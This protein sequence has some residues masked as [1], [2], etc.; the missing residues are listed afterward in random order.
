MFFTT[1]KSLAITAAFLLTGGT[2]SAAVVIT[3]W[4]LDNVSVSTTTGA[5]TSTIYDRSATAPGALTSGKITFDGT[6]A[7]SPGVKIVNDDPFAGD[8]SNGYNCI[9][10]NSGTTCNGAKQSGKRFKFQSTGSA[11]T[12]MVFNVNPNGTFTTTG[13]DGVYKV[14]QAFGN[15]T[16]KP[17][18]SFRVTLGTGVGTS[19]VPSTDGD[20]LSFV[21][22][23][24]TKPLNNSQFSSLFSNGLFGPV[25]DVHPLEGYFSNLRTGFNLAFDGSDSF[26]ST[27]LFGD[28]ESLFGPM[29][30]YNH[31]PL[32]YY[33]DSD[34]NK[35]TDDV[36]IAHQLT[37]GSWVQNRSVSSTG[38]V[39]TI[40]SGNDGTKYATLAALVA[41]LEATGLKQCSATLPGVA[42]LAGTIAIDDLAKFNL[43][44]YIDPTGYA[45]DQF[46][47][48]YASSLVTEQVPEPGSLALVMLALGTLGVTIRRRQKS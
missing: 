8:G 5:G 46:T 44:F 3:D 47:L 19:F 36:L 6:E 37:D 2:S 1:K 33:F 22:S 24:G 29:L 15:D 16:G 13:N 12:D 38:A 17:L 48:R 23:F 27:G 11:P 26:Q 34:G 21:Q 31:L 20:G 14:F 30:S 45:R 41:A 43:S 10:A 18:D 32:G 35:N 25:D 7:I 4:N 39:G 40:A 9:M 28:Y 42:C